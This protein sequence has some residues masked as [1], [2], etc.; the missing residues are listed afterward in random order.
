MSLSPRSMTPEQAKSYICCGP[1]AKAP[2]IDGGMCAG[3]RCMAWRWTDGGHVPA[4][5]PD[6]KGEG[7]TE[8]RD[9]P[10]TKGVCGYIGE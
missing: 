10:P 5:K 4:K 8:A 6:A 1:H 9:V 3:P 2:N 7:G